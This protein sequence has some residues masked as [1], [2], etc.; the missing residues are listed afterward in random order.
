MGLPDSSCSFSSMAD[1]NSV[2]SRFVSM[3]WACAGEEGDGFVACEYAGAFTRDG[4]RLP[5][6]NVDEEDR[7]GIGF[8]R[9]VGVACDIDKDDLP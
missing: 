8:V 7:E 6:Y 9:G 3:P 1:S 5:V 2:S 4:G